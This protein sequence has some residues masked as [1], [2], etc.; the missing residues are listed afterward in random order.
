MKAFGIDRYGGPEVLTLRDYP[1]PEPGPT[2]VLVEI[3]AASV[4]PVDFK[5]RSGG[6]K[7]L[8]KDRFPLIMGCDCSGEVVRVGRDVT[9]L[10]PGDQIFARLRKDRIGTFAER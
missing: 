1:E 3:H 4:N 7:V 5:I 8:V 2:D 6:V 9:K 10:R